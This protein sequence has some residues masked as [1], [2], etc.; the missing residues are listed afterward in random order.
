[1]KIFRF[2]PI[3]ALALCPGPRLHAEPVEVDGVLAVIND[4]VI[5]REQMREFVAPAIDGLQ[6]EYAG[7]PEAVFQQK[8]TGV[9]NDG[10]EQ[11]VERQLILHAFDT[12]GY[13]M[14]DSYLDEMVQERIRD[15][16][17][18]RVTLMKTLQAQGE[19]LEQFREDVRDQAI[20]SYMRSKN[21][22][23]EIVI[24]PFKIETYYQAHTNDFK[25]EDEV[26]LRMI[27]LN[28]TG[29]DDTDTVK[30]AREIRSQ[31]LAGAAFADMA[32]IYSQ[33]SLRSQGGDRGWIERS[34]LRPELADAAFAL[35]PGQVSDV[36]ETP[37]TC[38]LLLVEQKRPAHVK[39]LNEVR[40]EIE[41]NLRAQE[42]T[43]L[44]KQW[45]DRL[46]AKTFILYF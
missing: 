18:D 43:R 31:I 41:Q 5:T 25:L 22:A 12:E 11:L 6:R 8:L 26:S 28:K 32:A 34:V 44:Q 36:I 46:K 3:L 17:G 15:R 42:Q 27:T 2:I 38:Y 29:S 39:P 21:V 45:I 30:L 33:D 23:Q 9:I 24:S 10:L 4:T 19:T 13:R 16:Y 35:Q 37:N 1:M 40:N 14:P 7:Q 20:E